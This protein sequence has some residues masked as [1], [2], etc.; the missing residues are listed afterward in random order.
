[1]ASKVPA[2]KKKRCPGEKALNKS[3]EKKT[4]N[5]QFVLPP[6]CAA[7]S[8]TDSK[9]DVG[10]KEDPKVTYSGKWLVQ[11]LSFHKPAGIGFFVGSERMHVKKCQNK[12]LHEIVK[13]YQN[14]FSSLWNTMGGTELPDFETSP[15]WTLVGS[16][17]NQEWKKWSFKLGPLP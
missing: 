2:R 4:L 11:S 7:K 9:V 10:V 6:T 3:A 17:P 16:S 14:L 1:M 15:L 12:T 13:L 5:L 8:L